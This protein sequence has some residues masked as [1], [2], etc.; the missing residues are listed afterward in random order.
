MEGA[1]RVTI[2]GQQGVGWMEMG[3]ETDYLRHIIAQ[4]PN[5]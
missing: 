1:A 5:Y 4:R 3:W 2:D